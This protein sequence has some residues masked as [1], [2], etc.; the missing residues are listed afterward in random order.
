MYLNGS[1]IPGTLTRLQSLL[2][3]E[4]TD[5]QITPMIKYIPSGYVINTCKAIIAHGSHNTYA[6]SK[7][8]R[9]ST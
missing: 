3:Q 4:S 7:A 9:D 8:W 2:S 1:N 6:D 5:N